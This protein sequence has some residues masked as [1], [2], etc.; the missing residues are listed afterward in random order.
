L[1]QALSALFAKVG[2]LQ[3]HVVGIREEHG[4]V[5]DPERTGREEDTIVGFEA[6]RSPTPPPT[7]TRPTNI[8][9]QRFLQ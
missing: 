9:R 5:V 4:V 6:S 1:F 2:D 7:E 3:P 8:R